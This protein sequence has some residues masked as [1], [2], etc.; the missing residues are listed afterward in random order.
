MFLLTISVGRLWSVQS[1]LEFNVIK[2]NLRIMSDIK[3]FFEPFY[4]V[5]LLACF[6][7]LPLTT[8]VS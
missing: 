4:F 6:C 5:W 2:K 8:P 3:R 1:V 7:S